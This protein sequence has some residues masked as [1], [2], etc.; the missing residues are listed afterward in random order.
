MKSHFTA[1]ALLALVAGGALAKGQEQIYKAGGD[2]GFPTLVKQ[3]QPRY[4]PAARL[5]GLQGVVEVEAVVKA[6]G[7]VGDVRILKSLDPTLGLDDAAVAAT[8]QWVFTPAKKAGVPV[9]TYVTIVLEFRLGN[10]AQ[11]PAATSQDEFSK[12]AYP[13][14]TPGLVKPKLVKSVE[15]KYTSQA[16]RAKIQGTVAV[17]AVVLSDGTVGRARISKSLDPIYGL[18]AEAISA[19]LQ[20]TFEPAQLNGQAVPAVIEVNVGFR[21]H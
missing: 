10:Q 4:S 17:E 15:A 5:A 18:D 12:G 8:K 20:W 2:V 14:T 6:D 1:V 16:M 21:L 13:D 9:A 3:E 7:T 19:V 11:A